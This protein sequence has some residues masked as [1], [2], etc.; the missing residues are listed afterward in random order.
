MR[1]SKPTISKRIQE[2]YSSLIDGQSRLDIVQKGSKK[3]KISE[4]QV[5]KYIKKAKSLIQKEVIKNLE[6]DYAKAIRR[7][8]DLYKI[9]IKDKDY[10]LAMAANKEIAKL[11]GLASV[12]IEHTGD[13]KFIT[14][15]PE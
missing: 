2:V 12:Q 10:K 7:Y 5:D 15:I 6:Y 13:I 3:W 4:R 8:E 9:G 11:Q 1:A 14:N